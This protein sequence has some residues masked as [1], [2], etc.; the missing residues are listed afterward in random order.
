VCVLPFGSF[1]GATAAG[2]NL[3]DAV[4]HQWDIAVGWES[5][6]RSATS[7]LS[8]PCA[9]PT[10]WSPSGHGSRANSAP[11]SSPPGALAPALGS[12]RPRAG[13]PNDRSP[14][15]SLGR[16]QFSTAPWVVTPGR[17]RSLRAGHRRACGAG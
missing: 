12:W 10:S 13:K 6:S 2:I 17:P 7:S 11:R 8:S 4:V 9:S 3:F 16:G 5:V 1:D 14:H 15:P